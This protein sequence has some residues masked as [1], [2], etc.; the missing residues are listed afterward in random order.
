M[1]TQ[2]RI[3]RI[4]PNL[5]TSLRIMLSVALAFLPLLSPLF[6]SIYLLA[7][8]SDMLDGYF[9]RRWGVSSKMGAYLDSAADFILCAVL[10]YRF[11]PAYAWPGWALFWVGGIA[12][13]RLASLVVCYFKFHKF[14][15]LHTY[16][17][18]ATG[19]LLLCFPFLLRFFG[20]QATVILLCV[21][22]TLSALEEFM[23]LIKAKRLNPD[24]TTLFQQKDPEA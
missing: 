6:L 15:F 19:F 12:L 24:Q 10:L 5:I 20:M 14:T 11:L 3:K 4:L 13:L 1:E 2:S 22:A 23:I 18:K 8:L 9:A 21:A 16:A 17:N 7:G